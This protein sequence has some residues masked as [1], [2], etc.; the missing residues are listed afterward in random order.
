VN[1]N[2]KVVAVPN[3]TEDEIADHV[4]RLRTSSGNKAEK[5]KK[6]WHTDRPSIQGN[7]SPFKHY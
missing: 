1:G 2:S 4:S 6:Y 3:M 5:L 7:W